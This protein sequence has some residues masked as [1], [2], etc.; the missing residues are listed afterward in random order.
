[1]ER[2][3]SRQGGS[4][5]PPRLQHLL[6]CSFALAS[7]RKVSAW[8]PAPARRQ[9]STSRAG[10]D[11]VG[12]ALARR[13]RGFVRPGWGVSGSH[14]MMQALLPTLAAETR[15][16]MRRAARPTADRSTTPR[17]YRLRR[18]GRR[19]PT[20]SGARAR[21]SSSRGVFWC[22]NGLLWCGRSTP[23]E[24]VLSCKPSCVHEPFLTFDCIFA[25]MLF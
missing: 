4:G 18:Y 25:C 14:A 5:N 22:W 21:S 1:M 19:R 24:P 2:G 3:S 10:Q 12:P 6:C 15:K 11:W 13:P 17:H 7:Q 16:A 9:H 8:H 20:T 23:C